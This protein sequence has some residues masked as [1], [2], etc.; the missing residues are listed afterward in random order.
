MTPTQRSNC[1][2][3]TL[4]NTGNQISI[5]GKW[6]IEKKKNP[7]LFRPFLYKLNSSKLRKLIKVALNIREILLINREDLVRLN[8]TSVRGCNK[9]SLIEGQTVK[10]ISLMFNFYL[11]QVLLSFLVG[12]LA[13][14]FVSLYFPN[15]YQMPKCLT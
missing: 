4:E 6:Y 5:F 12:K 13:E 14:V 9:V 2:L 7:V 11:L 8:P 3:V 1:S 15:K 10:S